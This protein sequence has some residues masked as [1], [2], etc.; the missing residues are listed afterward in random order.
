MVALSVV[1]LLF[2]FIFKTYM[3]RGSSMI[4][5]LIE[6]N[7][8]YVICALYKPSQGDIVIMDERLQ[9]GDSIVKRVIAT[10][11]Q[12]LYIDGETG[13]ITVDGVVYKYPIATTTKNI[14]LN[15]GMVY[16]VI[17][18]EGHIFVMGDNRGNSLDSRYAKVG[19]VD[20]R[21]VIGRALFVISPIDQFRNIK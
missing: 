21:D 2:I 4:P 16:P 1:I 18:P 6:G 5:T 13:E 19:F 3:V 9:T 12:E 14:V 7:R 8:V 20:V 11:G 10:E 15:T 17:V